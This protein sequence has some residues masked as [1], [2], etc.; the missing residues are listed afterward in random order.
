MVAVEQEMACWICG[1][2]ADSAEHR[3]KKS[4]LTRAHGKGSYKGDRA[5]VHVSGETQRMVQGPNA[6]SLKYPK[7][8]CQS[9]NN[10]ASQSWDRAYDKLI[11]WVH[12][13]E[14]AVLHNRSIDLVKVFGDAFD[15]ASRDLY[16]YY[17]KSFGCRLA[18]VGH[19]VPQDVKDIL[20]LA[21]SESNFIVTF[22]VNE[23]VLLLSSDIRY[24]FIGQAGLVAWL[25][26]NDQTI[27][28]G[29]QTSEHVSWFTAN[30]W[31]CVEPEDSYGSQWVGDRKTV[32]LGSIS[33]LTPEQRH[34]LMAW[35]GA[36]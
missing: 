22:S 6:G 8:L 20:G 29:Y 7:S 21:S 36:T 10:A 25:D 23:D 18:E 31:Y 2:P 13:N 3:F 14:D 24:G 11:N 27:V 35:H 5:L 1:A 30:L 17:A 19:K 12:A 26:K 15:S 28:N 33:P 4:D 34:E 9:C 32:A 16:R